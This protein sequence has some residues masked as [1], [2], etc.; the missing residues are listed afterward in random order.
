[1]QQVS[2]S[3]GRFNGYP[4]TCPPMRETHDMGPSTPKSARPNDN[5]ELTHASN[6]FR[7]QKGEPPVI[8]GPSASSWSIRSSGIGSISFGPRL[9]GLTDD[10]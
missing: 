2:T 6:A 5:I 4:V 8:F 7:S 3:E 10:E 1:M 9:D